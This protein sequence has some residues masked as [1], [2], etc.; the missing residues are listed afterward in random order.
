M[1][2]YPEAVIIREAA[3]PVSTARG[4]FHKNRSGYYR[5][6]AGPKSHAPKHEQEEA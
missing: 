5:F 1:D 6:W 4:D 3:E 2:A